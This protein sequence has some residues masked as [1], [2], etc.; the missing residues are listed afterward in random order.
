MVTLV[1]FHS[2]LEL[3]D[4]IFGWL[5]YVVRLYLFISCSNLIA[6]SISNLC[7]L[8]QVKTSS[9]LSWYIF[10]RILVHEVVSMLVNLQNLGFFFTRGCIFVEKNSRKSISDCTLF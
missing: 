3:F 9:L 8:K 6:T 1:V 2:Y 4:V 5:R 10:E 7:T